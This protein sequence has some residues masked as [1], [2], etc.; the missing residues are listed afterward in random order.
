[1]LFTEEH[2]EIRRTITNFVDREINP[3]VD[4]WEREGI[5]PAHEVFKR[6]G[7]LG[8]LGISKPVEYGGLAAEDH[9]RSTTIAKSPG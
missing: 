9:D 4:E 1:M 2:R 8:L 6:A 5:F 7:D 3:H